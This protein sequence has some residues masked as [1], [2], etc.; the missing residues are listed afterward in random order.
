MAQTPAVRWCEGDMID[1]T[2]AAAVAAGDVVVLGSRLLGVA[3]NDIAADALGA[4]AVKGV[5]KVPKKTG[6]I[7][8]GAPVYWNPTGDPVTGTADTGAAEGSPSESNYPA[9]PAV[10]A[11]G[12]S[13]EY[14]YVSLTPGYLSRDPVNTVAAAG[15]NQA[16]AAQVY[17][18][19]NVV[20]G[21]DD[22]KG[23]ILPVA[24]AGMKV[25]IKV[26]DG[27]DLKV[28]PNTGAAINGLSAN[29]AITVVDDVSFMLYATSATQWYTLPLL[30]S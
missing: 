21:P 20:T 24:V 6:A 25:I 29:G 22:T 26:G 4:L 7:A 17:E 19:I 16:T 23:V 8:V 13:D 3:V 9:G 11:A 10:L 30:P 2:P 15:T 5:F 27:A 12:S 14:V 28:Y 1:Y 18:G